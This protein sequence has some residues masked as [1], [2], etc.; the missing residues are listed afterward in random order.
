MQSRKASCGVF[1]RR[2]VVTNMSSQQPEKQLWLSVC[3]LLL[4][5]STFANFTRGDI[6]PRKLLL[7]TLWNVETEI[8]YYCFKHC[9]LLSTFSERK[10][11]KSSRFKTLEHVSFSPIGVCLFTVVRYQPITLQTL[12]GGDFKLF[13]FFWY[14]LQESYRHFSMSQGFDVYLTI[15]SLPIH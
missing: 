12:E 14:N 7:A 10:E 11:A 5:S 8:S 15:T 9:K 2:L 3:R 1:L 6:S 4:K 13:N